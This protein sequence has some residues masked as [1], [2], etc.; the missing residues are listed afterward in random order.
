MRHEAHQNSFVFPHSPALPLSSSLSLSLSLSLNYEICLSRAFRKSSGD[1]RL[2]HLADPSSDLPSE[3]NVTK[4]A[5]HRDINIHYILDDPRSTLTPA[6]GPL[7]A[8]FF[9]SSVRTSARSL[10]REATAHP[11]TVS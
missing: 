11:R 9:R 10:A 5:G 3:I 6:G 1:A 4:D 7:P 8:V 2:R